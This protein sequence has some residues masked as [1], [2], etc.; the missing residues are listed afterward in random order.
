MST[1]KTTKI[2][3]PDAMDSNIV[4]HPD[5][6]I[7]LSEASIDIS[8]LS[9][10]N[11]ESGLLATDVKS[12]ID[13]VAGTVNSMSTISKLVEDDS[14]Q[15]GGDLDV[16]GHNIVSGAGEDIKIM[17]SGGGSVGIGVENPQVRL[18]VDGWIRANNVALT[19]AQDQAAKGTWDRG[20]NFFST[21]IEIE[22]P[23]NA[24]LSVDFNVSARPSGATTTSW[25]YIDAL[26]NGNSIRRV[27]MPVNTG[28]SHVRTTAG[29]GMVVLN[30][31]THSFNFNLTGQAGTLNDSDSEKTGLYYRVDAVPT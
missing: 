29:I 5:G 4:L 26:V 10:D 31:G 30:S 22:L 21:D 14:P 3:H 27:A 23:F 15:L 7:D 20:T 6:T 1:V 12:A 17:P 24:V 13:E 9:Y 8:S 2:Q 25:F 18:D 16:N 28:D 11:T 19:L